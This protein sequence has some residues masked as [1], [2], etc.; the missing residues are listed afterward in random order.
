MLDDDRSYEFSLK[1]QFSGSFYDLLRTRFMISNATIQQYFD[2][3]IQTT[4]ISLPNDYEKVSKLLNSQAKLL[5]KI[6]APT[7]S[8]YLAYL[9]SIGLTEQTTL[10]I[11][12]LG[13]SGTIQKLLSLL[14]EKPSN[15]HYLIASKPGLN[16]VYGQTA[17]MKGYL[18]ESVSMGDGYLPLDRS[19]FLEA[20]LT[21]PNGQFQDIRHSPLPH[22]DFEYYYGRKVNAQ[23]YIHE[24][25][26]VMQGAIDYVIHAAKHQVSFTAN[27]V[28]QT[29]NQHV[30]KPNMIPR[31]LWPLFTID[32][33]VAGNGTVDP[34]QFFGLR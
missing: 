21:S 17:A 23:K 20:L 15:G 34:L 29:L 27:E 9:Q 16:Y 33:D 10:N 28:E 8:A 12:D 24:L 32:D 25:E 31:A 3:K 22:G 5:G 4:F 7:K 2:K 18:K 1:G 26:Q 6:I 13:Y 19:M 14:L 11:V 30:A